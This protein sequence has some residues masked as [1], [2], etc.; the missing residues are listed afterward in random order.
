MP[1]ASFTAPSQLTRCIGKTEAEVGI[2][3]FRRVIRNNMTQCAAL[4]KHYWWI[5]FAPVRTKS[6]AAPDS[7]AQQI[8]LEGVG[9]EGRFQKTRRSKSEENWRNSM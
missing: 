3:P 9:L 1:Q 6:N 8:G 5:Q 2:S 7:T 4:L